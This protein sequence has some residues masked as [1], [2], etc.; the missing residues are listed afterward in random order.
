MFYI[1]SADFICFMLSLLVCLF[2]LRE[3][4]ALQD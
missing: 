4:T 1:F 2:I 3:K